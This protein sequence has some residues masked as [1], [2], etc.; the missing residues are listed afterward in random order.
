M[1]G[2]DHRNSN[3]HHLYDLF[4]SSN[5]DTFKYGISDD[6][7]DEDGLSARVRDQLEALNLAAEYQKFEAEILL[8][9]I[10]GRKKALE[11]E[12]HY[13]DAYYERHGHNPIGNKFPIRKK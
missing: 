7:I 4:R 2:N 12:R 5:H 13:I 3:P 1:H 9:D 6:P 10:P 11:V 8:I